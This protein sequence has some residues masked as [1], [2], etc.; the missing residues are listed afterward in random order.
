[1]SW[2]APTSWATRGLDSYVWGSVAGLLRTD[3]TWTYCPPTW[4]S[5]S[6][7]SFSAPMALIT[8]GVD[9]EAAWLVL[10]QAAATAATAA[11]ANAA[12]HLPNFPGL[13]LS[14]GCARQIME[15]KVT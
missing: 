13:I 15:C 4:L 5:T 1:M 9:V 12:V 11:R 2:A 10:P 14:D 8:L 3:E 6:A 7:Y